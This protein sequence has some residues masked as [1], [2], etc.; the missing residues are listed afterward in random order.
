M[1]MNK[2]AANYFDPGFATIWGNALGIL[3]NYLGDIMDANFT[4]YNAHFLNTV[5][6]ND[7]IA[8]VYPQL[9]PKAGM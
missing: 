1:L 7:L 9:K 2:N 5:M 3:N 6:N 8:V 4:F